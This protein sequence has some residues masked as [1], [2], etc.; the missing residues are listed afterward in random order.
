MS[1]TPT[2]VACPFCGRSHQMH[3]LPQG[4]QYR[5]HCGTCSSAGPVMPSEELA[6]REWNRRG[7]AL[8]APGAAAAADSAQD[9]TK[10]AVDT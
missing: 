4:T 10:E 7:I 2:F 3:I 9:A 6:A 5:V 1:E 8:G